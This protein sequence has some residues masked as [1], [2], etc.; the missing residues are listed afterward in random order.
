MKQRLQKCIAQATGLSRRKAEEKIASGAVSVNGVKITDQGTQA[1]LSEDRIELDGVALKAPENFHYLLLHKPRQVMTT[2]SDPEGRKTVMDLLPETHQNLY[3]VGRLDF[4]SEGFLL[5]TNDGVWANELMH[6]RYEV[7]K[8]YEVTT[9]FPVSDLDQR[10][11]VRRVDLE[12]GPG[13]FL[14]IRPIHINGN[15]QECVYSVIVEEGR[16]RF[17]RRMFDALKNEVVRLRRVRIGPL[18]LGTLP[19]GEVRV[20]TPIEVGKLSYAKKR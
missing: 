17:I 12:D 20:L 14:S 15:P 6:P 9:R 3:P 19:S 13:K 7:E 5:L 2:R 18:E 8:E 16:N 10:K 4:D 11:L 1:S